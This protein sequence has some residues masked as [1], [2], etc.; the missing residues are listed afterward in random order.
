M[1]DSNTDKEVR[2]RRSVVQEEQELRI[3]PGMSVFL[4]EENKGNYQGM[5]NNKRI[6]R[7]VVCSQ[8]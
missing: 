4:Q 6:D 7:D 5:E 8:G 1:Q 2:I 3:A